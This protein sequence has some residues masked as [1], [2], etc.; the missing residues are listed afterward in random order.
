MGKICDETYSEFLESIKAAGI[1]I[2]NELALRERLAETQRWRFAFMT[3][4]LHGRPLGISFQERTG[5]RD[6]D[7]INGAFA[8]YQFPA[9]SG[10]LF[11]AR[12]GAVQ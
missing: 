8:R 10:S 3:L 2:T 9:D 7:Q 12:L 4:A 11:A 5:E 1:E 6:L